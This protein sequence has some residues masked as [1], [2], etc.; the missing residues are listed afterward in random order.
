MESMTALE[1]KTGGNAYNRRK[2]LENI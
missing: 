1:E 2:G